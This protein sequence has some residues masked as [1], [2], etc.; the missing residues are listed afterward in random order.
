MKIVKLLILLLCICICS[1]GCSQMSQVENKAY[2]LTMGIDGSP[3][4]GI[5]LT[6]QIPKIASSGEQ[7]NS[8]AGG[9]GGNYFMFSAKGNS[10]EDA[11]E[12][13]EW[14][15]PRELNLSHLKLIVLS[16]DLIAAGNCR[17]LLYDIVHTERLFSAARLVVCEGNA[18]EFIKNTKPVIGSRLSTDILSTFAHYGSQGFVPDSNLA[19]FYYAMESVYSDPLA[20]YAVLSVSEN[21]SYADQMIK[22]A[23][24]N[25]GSEIKTHYI[26]S[27]LFSEGDF[28]GIFDAKQ[29]L[30]TGL[31][32]GNVETFRYQ[33]DGQ[34][35]EIF[36]NGSAQ[37]KIDTSVNPA[38]IHTLLRLNVSAQEELPDLEGL[39]QK[40]EN[41]I[42]KTVHAA[43]VFGVEPFGFADAAANNFLTLEDWIN[44]EW[45][46]QFAEAHVEIEVELRR[47]GT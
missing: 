10:F 3:D 11:L 36:P 45:N 7:E 28:K 23:I 14:I 35:L 44:Y 6:V 34:G 22:E 38:R 33:H 32:K 12:K 37:I 43:Q 13:L 25:T 8:A 29:T 20:A 47:T 41:E 16:N 31:I 21:G 42:L 2:V 24:N 26:G 9:S 17:R 40:L 18:S 5:E 1:C 39:K 19:D 4:T 27:A 30:H 46:K 15:I